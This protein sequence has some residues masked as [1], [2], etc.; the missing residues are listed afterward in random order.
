MAFNCAI[1]IEVTIPWD[2]GAVGATVLTDALPRKLPPIPTDEFNQVVV[3]QVK[4]R[5][6]ATSLST[7]ARIPTTDCELFVT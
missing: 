5:R 2:A 3:L 7:S 6:S 1:S 4:V